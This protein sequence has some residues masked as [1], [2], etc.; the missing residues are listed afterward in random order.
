MIES[1][2]VNGRISGISIL[3]KSPACILST[4]GSY[5]AANGSGKVGLF[6]AR[7]LFSHG[8][9]VFLL[10]RETDQ[11]FSLETLS[12]DLVDFFINPKQSRFL[13]E[14]VGFIRA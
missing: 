9:S 3:R 1:S 6:D 2:V 10:T 4:Y 12:L 13:A 7:S 5:S 11:G 14:Y 8:D